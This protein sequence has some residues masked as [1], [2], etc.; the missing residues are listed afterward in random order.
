[1]TYHFFGLSNTLSPPIHTKFPEPPLILANRDR[2][3]HSFNGLKCNKRARGKTQSG[4]RIVEFFFF[5]M[6]FPSPAV[7]VVYGSV[8]RVFGRELWCLPMLCLSGPRATVVPRNGAMPTANQGAKT[9]R[10]LDRVAEIIRGWRLRNGR[11]Q[12]RGTGTGSA[13]ERTSLPGLGE[14]PPRNVEIDGG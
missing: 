13:T 4:R 3:L 1:M 8:A 7:V 2:A 5:S 10:N 12:G 11:E 6:F 9:G 14:S